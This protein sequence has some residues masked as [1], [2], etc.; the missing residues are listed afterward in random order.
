MYEMDS[1]GRL[2]CKF[3][4]FPRI[5]QVLAL[6]S[7]K[8]HDRH[9]LYFYLDVAAHLIIGTNES[10]NLLGGTCVLVGGISWV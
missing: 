5:L 9:V 7:R 6:E 4:L 3:G 1:S 2:S 10:T 8:R